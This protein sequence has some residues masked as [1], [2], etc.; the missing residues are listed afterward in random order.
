MPVVIGNAVI[1]VGAD[2]T[3]FQKNLPKQTEPA[4]KAAGINMAGA[5]G[6][7][8]AVGAAAV[9]AGVAGVIGTALVKGFARLTAIDDA[10]AKLTGLGYSATQVTQIMNNA[11]TSVKGTA[12]GL[13]DA[14]SQAANLVAA[15]IKPGA[16]LTR[17]LKLLGDTSQIAGVGLNEIGSIFG[18]VAAGGK[19]TMEV[20]GQLQDRGVPVLKLLADQTGKSMGEVSQLISA[21]AVD[22]ETF[23]KAM[24]KGLGGAALSS[25]NTFSGAMKNVGAALGRLGA[26]VLGGAFAKM[27][28]LMGDS[29]GAIDSLGP[30]AK[31]VG[32]VVGTAFGKAADGLGD[33]LAGLQS[34]GPV[35]GFDG[36]MNRIGL[37]LSALVWSFENGTTGS[38]GFVGAMERLGEQ[39]GIMWDA[40]MK[41]LGWMK[42]HESVSK[43]LAISMGALLLVTQ[44]HAAVLAVQAAGGLAAYIAQINIVQNVTK[45][46]AAVQWVLDSAFLA[47]P[48]TWIIAGIIAL[49]AAVV[50]AYRNSETFRDVVNSAWAAVKNAIGAVTD[51][52][53]GSVVPW[54]V[55]AWDTIA[56]GATALWN[57]TK[58]VWNGIQSTLAAVQSWVSGTFGPSWRSFAAIVEFAFK[59]VEI[60]A[61][62]TWK[63][64]ILPLFEI[65]KIGLA[66]L[67]AQFT[68]L[69]EK[70]VKPAFDFIVTVIKANWAATQVIFDAINKALVVVGGFFSDLYDKYV[71]PKMDLIGSVIKLVWT[72]QVQP[73]FDAI[74]KGVAAV[75]TAF[76]KAVTGVKVAWEML[77]AY[78]QAPVRFVIETVLNNGL[79][80]AFNWLGS[81][82]GGPTIDNIPLPFASGGVL[83]GYT[84]GRDVHKFYSPSGGRLEL[85]GGEAIMRPEF[86]QAM[87]GPGGI[88]RLN[89]LA[90][91]GM[92]S[93][94]YAGGGVHSFAG[95]GVIDWITSQA[96]SAF[97]WMSDTASATWKA[98]SDPLAYIKA[99]MPTVPGSTALAGYANA[100]A[101]KL[102]TAAVDKIK[103]LFEEFKAAYASS[104]M[105]NV[106]GWAN[107]WAVLQKQFPSAQ[108][109]SAMRPGAV[110]SSGNASYHSMGRAIDVTPSAEIFNWIKQTYGKN[111]AEL[112]YSPMNGAQVK[113]G[114]NYLYGEPVRSDHWDHVH[115]AMAN[116][117]VLGA[118]GRPLLMDSGGVL[119]KGLSMVQNNTGGP[120]RLVRPGSGGDTYIEVTVSVDDL[121][122]M[123][124]VA[125]FL[126]MLNNSRTVQRK[127][128]RSGTVNV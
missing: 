64:A 5:L 60:I 117:G 68:W 17:T 4:A 51:W 21:G 65:V 48:G 29:I 80:K 28:K 112:I 127:T 44:A 25:G 27:P 11:L 86:T 70:A 120:E 16:E 24:E 41:V 2:A 76:E 75:Q 88:A 53:T 101:G 97:D 89:K 100:A 54:L 82:V 22:F 79:V 125:D 90:R 94:Q 116:G 84:P 6:K 96:A 98:L 81:K 42:E 87:G 74:N 73:V 105:G 19:V 33:F 14:A 83:P 49:V 23:Q 69:Y 56:D 37:G 110:T 104:G 113:N 72:S 26:Q 31:R 92:L 78:T 7:S 1:I 18:K 3:D 50:L 122:K 55:K 99:A 34:K 128:K 52:V 109:F 62:A 61:L 91:M 67:G 58:A 108:L 95:G 15:G 43:G 102:L 107:Q 40:G 114:A 63:L 126:E 124:T 57:S 77:K 45:V 103:S 20:V 121:E 13:G 36:D 93:S 47:W 8:L 9:G 119:P 38:D 32:E 10:K 115:W 30:V 35:D 66:I 106:S 85:S 123:A 12:F 59:A 118:V 71:K 46:W 111:I 39:L